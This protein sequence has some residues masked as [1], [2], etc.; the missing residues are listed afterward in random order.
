MCALGVEV[1][2]PAPPLELVCRAVLAALTWVT[3]GALR[4][5]CLSWAGVGV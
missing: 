5:N 3:V 1:V 2:P 4:W